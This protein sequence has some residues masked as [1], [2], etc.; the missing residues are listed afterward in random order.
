MIEGNASLLDVDEIQRA[1]TTAAATAAAA[2]V[3]GDGVMPVTVSS[4]TRHRHTP[5]VCVETVN[6]KVILQT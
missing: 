4:S 6:N 2:V 3:A 5:L 1:I